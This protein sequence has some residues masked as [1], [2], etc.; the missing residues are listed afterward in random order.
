MEINVIEELIFELR[1]LPGVSRKQAEKI[2]NYLI[3]DDN[4]YVEALIASIK[5]LKS[6][7]SYCPECNFIRENNYC[8]NCDNTSRLDTLMIVESSKAL[9]KIDAMN[10]YHGYYYVLPF[11]MSIKEKIAKDM[12]Y[13]Y[14]ALFNYINKKH[15]NEVIIVLSPTLE[16]EMTT[17]HL[18]KLCEKYNIKTTRAAIGMP[19]G[20]NLEYLDSFTIMQSIKNRDKQN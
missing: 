2:V 5:N 3:A 14:Q 4:T 19:L 7:I 15:L 18:L 9:E 11:L 12:N 17:T 16:G 8:P 10:F 20:S 13:D 6:Q 1:K